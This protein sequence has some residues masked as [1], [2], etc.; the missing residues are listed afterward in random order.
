R[1]VSTREFGFAQR[2]PSV[3]QNRDMAR[4]SACLHIGVRPPAPYRR[5]ATSGTQPDYPWSAALTAGSRPS[6]AR[7]GPPEP[8]KAGSPKDRA[9]APAKDNRDPSHRRRRHQ[10]LPAPALALR[11]C[12]PAAR[13]PDPRA[14]PGN[15][16]V[17]WTAEDWPH[18][19]P[20]R[21]DPAFRT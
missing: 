17:M 10:D 18:R 3:A 12:V 2:R 4:K 8:L 7:N 21:R 19:A 5:V 20:Y 16:A 13:S 14:S 9:P 6:P 11:G 1:L 15:P